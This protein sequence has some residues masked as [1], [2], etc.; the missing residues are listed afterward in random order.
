MYAGGGSSANTLKKVN[1][2]K[3]SN[4]ECGEK[5]TNISGAAINDGHICFFEENKSACNV[6]TQYNSDIKNLFKRNLGDIRK[7]KKE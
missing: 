3:I 1:M 2:G 4:L 5:W 7:N 6:S